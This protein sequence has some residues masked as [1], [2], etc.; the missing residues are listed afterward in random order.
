MRCR[1][2][3]HLK[4]VCARISRVNVGWAGPRTFGPSDEHCAGVSAR[5]AH[6]PVHAPVPRSACRRGV[7]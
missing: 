5:P 6:S 1:L 2:C 7:A 3:S 4:S